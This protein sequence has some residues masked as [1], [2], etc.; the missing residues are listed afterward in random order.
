MIVRTHLGNVL[1][2]GDHALGYD[3]RNANFN[4]DH[5]DHIAS[6]YG[7]SLPDVI[8]VKKSYP[9][10]RKKSR[11]RNWKLKKMTIEEEVEAI[12]KGKA[13]KLQAE[14]DYE[15]FLRDIEEDPELR[16]MINLYKGIIGL[17]LYFKTLLN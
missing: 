2:P 17:L 16:G 3:L 12:G 15:M 9:N 5:W 11:S 4:N 6:L 14:I 7:G 1:R 8:L 10:A 13:E